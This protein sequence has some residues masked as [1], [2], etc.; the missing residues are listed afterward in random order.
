MPRKL[1]VCFDGTWNTP[2][3][4]DD[5]DKRVE[6]NAR[7]FY[8]SVRDGRSGASDQ[9]K[10]YAEGPGGRW[11]RRIPGLFGIG[12]SRTIRKGYAFLARNYQDGDEIYV[13][14]FSRGAYAARSLVGLL[15]TCGLI[16]RYE[17]RRVLNA[18]EI[19][20]TRGQGPDSEMAQAFREHYARCVRVAFVGVWDTVGALGIPL[21]SFEIFNRGFYE[22][23]DTELSGMVDHAYHAMAIDEHRLEYDVTLWDP[24]KKPKQEVE[25]RWFVGAHA[26]VG[27]GY[28]DRRL[29]DITLKWMQEKAQA[30]GLALDPDCIPTI[31]EE[32]VLAPVRDSFWEFLFGIYRHFSRRYYRT[33]SETVFGNEVLDDTVYRRLARDQ[34][35]RPKNPG[36][37]EDEWEEGLIN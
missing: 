23:H 36:L 8:S 12:L 15:R 2:D 11:Y 34:G 32:N 9:I 13:L 29:S 20:R 21:R 3:R 30:C 31:T 5:L 24:I 7:R 22:F 16:H 37:S 18:Y 1:I 14:G 33:I 28:R 10:W 19:Y 17:K 25:Q 27:G 4:G 35:Y 26:D 6:T